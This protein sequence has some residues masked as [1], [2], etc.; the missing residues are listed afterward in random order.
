MGRVQPH[1]HRRDIGR[2]GGQA[3][4]GQ[5]AAAAQNGIGLAIIFHRFI[6][7]G[8]RVIRRTIRR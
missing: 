6:L 2:T 3:H 4:A 5:Q 1:H 8:F 7:S